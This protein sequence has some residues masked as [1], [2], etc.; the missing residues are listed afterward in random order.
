MSKGLVK[1]FRQTAT[2]LLTA[3]TAIAPISAFS[4]ANAK[5]EADAVPAKD[6]VTFEDIWFDDTRDAKKMD[7]MDVYNASIGDKQGQIIL[8]Y[9]DGFSESAV[10]FV[11]DN[12]ESTGF[13]VFLA[14]GLP[15][16]PGDKP[17]MM[18]MING[19]YAGSWDLEQTLRAIP[20][21]DIE[22]KAE[23]LNIK[24]R[25]KIANVDGADILALNNPS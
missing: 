1:H 7:A 3:L 15:L 12:L 11:H 6:S 16:N 20:S 22:E 13:R 8:Y 2:G 10:E 21:L 24:P 18:G 5:A 14:K 17:Q 23:E 9:S 4:Q 25:P 19:H